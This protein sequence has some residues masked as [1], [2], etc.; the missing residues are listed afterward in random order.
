MNGIKKQLNEALSENQNILISSTIKTHEDTIKA[1]HKFISK[2]FKKICMITINEPVPVLMKKLEK[3]G[4]DFSN[5][6]FIDCISQSMNIKITRSEKCL[7]IAS[8]AALTELSIAIANLTKANK[9]DIIVLDSVSSLLIY[10]QDVI[11]LKFMHF[12][13]IKVRS[14]NIKGAYTIMK[15]G[16]EQILS[17][18]ALFADKILEF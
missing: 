1:F 10:N 9:I 11:T 8:P 17:D 12:L 18:L 14:M 7:A 6:Y 3:D 2:N 5:Y 15:D 13:M 16:K 4:T